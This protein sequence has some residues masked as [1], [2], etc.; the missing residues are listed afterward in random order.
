[1]IRLKEALKGSLEPL[2]RR[3]VWWEGLLRSRW[4]ALVGENFAERTAI[5]RLRGG[6]LEVWV[7]SGPWAQEFAFWRETLLGKIRRELGAEVKEIKVRTKPPAPLRSREQPSEAPVGEE[8][9]PLAVEGPVAEAYRRWRVA[10]RRLAYRRLAG[11]G[12]LC[13]NCGTAHG[14]TEDFCPS[15]RLERSKGGA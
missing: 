15:C 2:G 8:I 11:G 6:N 1:M 3:E 14:D 12:R 10:Q 13:R 9:P 4:P 5:G 7:E